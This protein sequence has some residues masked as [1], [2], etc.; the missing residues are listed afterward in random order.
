MSAAD[1]MCSYPQF[2]QAVPGKPFNHNSHDSGADITLPVY[3]PPTSIVQQLCKALPLP[4][5]STAVLFFQP[6]ASH[7]LE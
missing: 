2:A 7:G 3:T 1:F 6:H 5:F 4:Q